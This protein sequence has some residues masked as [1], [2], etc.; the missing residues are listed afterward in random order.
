MQFDWLTQSFACLI[1]DY[2]FCLIVEFP[3]LVPGYQHSCE[4]L[5]EDN[6]ESVKVS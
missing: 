6:N 1:Y 3:S 2:K 4:D 5:F